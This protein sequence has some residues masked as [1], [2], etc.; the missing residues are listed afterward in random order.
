MKETLPLPLKITNNWSHHFF[1]C[2]R[3][4]DRTE[5]LADVSRDPGLCRC[6]ISRMAITTY[7]FQERKRGGDGKEGSDEGCEER[8][9]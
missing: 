7:S 2:H 1:I 8:E 6:H 9:R 5:E 3:M 4:P